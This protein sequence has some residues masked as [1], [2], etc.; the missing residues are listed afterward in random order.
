MFF[1]LFFS[2]LLIIQFLVYWHFRKFGKSNPYLPFLP[3]NARRQKI[4]NYITSVPFIVFNLPYIYLAVNRSDFSSISGPLYHFGVIPFYIFQAATIF[5][6]IALIAVKLIKLPFIIFY[7]IAKKIKFFREKI[8]A[9]KAKRKFKKFDDSRRKFIRAG[10]V[11]FTGYAFTSA[12]IGILNKD[13]FSVTNKDIVIKNLPEK[14]KGLRVALISDVHSGPFMSEGLMKKY[15]D[16]INN[17][18]ADIVL[19]PGD[20]T[21][22]QRSEALPFTK[23]FR[24]IKAKHGVYA[25]LGNHD[26]FHDAEYV[27]KAVLNETPIKLLRN[28]NKILTINNEKLLIMGM[29]DTRQS[30]AKYDETIFNYFDKT[31][32]GA[33]ESLKQ[34]NLLYEAVPK[35]LV[36]HKPYFFKDFSKE[37]IDLTV[38]GHTHGGQIVFAKAGKINIS[39]ASSVSTY[40]EG[41]YKNGDLNM[42]VTRGIGTVGLPLRLNCPPEVVILTLK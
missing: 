13:E 18:N 31:V 4:W 17:L 33:K 24:D 11:L 5:I 10:G 8:D 6:G 32:S 21:N 41:L 2:I 20:L 29:E 22:S 34:S 14:L 12:S 35:I 15:V 28:E 38:S 9:I 23:V 30:G 7:F 3:K 42:Y 16:F 37:N 25:T 36:Y 1:L 19:I 27:A 39:F 26:Y 40:I